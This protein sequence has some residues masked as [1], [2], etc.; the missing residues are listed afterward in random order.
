LQA[1]GLD[2]RASLLVP[3]LLVAAGAVVVWSDLDAAGRAR[4]LDGAGSGQRGIVWLRIGLGVTLAIIG[5]TVIATRGSSPSVVVDSLLASLAVLLGLIIIAA[6]WALRLWTNARQEQEAA[7]RANERAD[8]AAHLHDSVLQTLALIQRRASD[9]AAVTT[10]ARSQERELRSW[11]YGASVGHDETLA[12]AIASGSHEV[13]DLT[14]VPVELVV[15]GDRP[16]EEHGVALARALREA[17]LNA[18]RHGQPPVTAYVEIGPGGVE[19]FVR[20]RGTG[21]DLDAVPEDRLGVRQSILGRMERHGGSARVRRR[22]DGTEVE[23]T[24]PALEGAH[25]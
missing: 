3:L 9:P 17:L 11:L 19:A 7:A 22:E 16:M 14:S 18:T 8:I 21:F 10:L 20:D 15:T 13:E 4:A 5:L 24:L 12:A 2:V 25:A 1:V 23:L 6:P